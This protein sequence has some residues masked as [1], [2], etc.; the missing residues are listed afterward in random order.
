MTGFV[1]L[2]KIADLFSVHYFFYLFG[3][4]LHGKFWQ[5]SQTAV[6]GSD[7][8]G[9]SIS[10]VGSRITLDLEDPTN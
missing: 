8:I 5:I 2:G 10:C 1:R 4:L 9:Y 6:F 3:Y 7:A